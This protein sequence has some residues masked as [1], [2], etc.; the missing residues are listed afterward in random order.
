MKSKWRGHKIKLKKGIWLYNDT[1]KPVRDNINISCGFCGR[2][3]TKEGYD[4]CLGTLPGLTN[5][6]CGHG[7]IEEAYVQFSDGH[8]IDRQSADIIIKMLKRRSI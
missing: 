7:N 4:A 6:C 8:S 5:A 2:P 1:N 3:K